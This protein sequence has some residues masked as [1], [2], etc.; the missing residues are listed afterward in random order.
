MKKTTLCLPDDLKAE[1][2]RVAREERRSE[3]ELIRDALAAALDARRPPKPRVA[4]GDSGDP[5][6]ASNLD[7]AME[8]FG[9][10]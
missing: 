9:T 8:G 1:L 6:L 7:N 5:D 10:R 4:L 3:A 2:E